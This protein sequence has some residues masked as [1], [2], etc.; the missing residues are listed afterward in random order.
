[1]FRNVTL[2]LPGGQITAIVGPSGSGKTTLLQLVNGLREPNEGQVLVLGNPVPA[3][4][5][6]KFRRG[7]GYA[8]QNAGLFPHLTAYQNTSLVAKLSG[9]DGE[10]TQARVLELF[11]M[12]GL[13][14]E[15][16]RR[17][18]YELSGG[19]QQRV[20]LCRALMLRP[21]L[22]LLDEP[23]SGIDVLNRKDIMARFQRLRQ[24]DG[25]TALMVTHDISE[26]LHLSNYLVVM[27]NHQVVQ[28]GITA[29]VVAS[30]DPDY[31]A[32]LL[33]DHR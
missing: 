19:Q 30:P 6:S 1:M 4:K 9:W 24:R 13:E 12:M 3:T 8:V 10:A 2:E 20:G 27:A 17:Y 26:A 28:H 33:T 18:P 16:L 7:I 5:Q 14:S 15:L 22:I 23:F 29:E 31:V 32:P 21:E 11:E 25:F